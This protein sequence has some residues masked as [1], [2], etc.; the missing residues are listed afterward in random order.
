MDTGRGHSLLEIFIVLGII[1][2]LLSLSLPGYQELVQK[3]AGNSSLRLLAKHIAIARSNAIATNLTVT[4]CPSD[5]G[6]TCSRT[7]SNGYIVFTD[8][9]EDRIINQD[10]KLIR[11]QQAR[12]RSGAITWRAFQNRQYLQI[13]AMGFMRHQSGNFTYCPHSNVPAHAHQIIVNA[14][15]RTRFAIDSDGDGIREGSNG[16]P[17]NCNS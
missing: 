14:T 16:T 13:D 15:G 11:H 2:I 9:N 8:R 10:D 17:L 6:Q 3:T 12:S 5:D 1:G 4:L 7:W